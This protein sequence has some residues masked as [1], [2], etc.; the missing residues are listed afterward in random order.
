MMQNVLI[1][2]QNKETKAR[3]S[4]Q[5]QAEV[6]EVLVDGERHKVMLHVPFSPEH[7][8]SDWVLSDYRTG[9]CIQPT[10]AYED[11]LIESGNVTYSKLE[12]AQFIVDKI[13]GRIGAEKFK[14]VISEQPTIND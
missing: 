5:I 3:K 4:H 11:M 6:L 2:T 1:G 9:W 8:F 12:L 7:V 10:K 13:I 14:K